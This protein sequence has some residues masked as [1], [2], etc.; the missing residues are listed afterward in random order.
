LPATAGR[1]AEPQR[2]ATA[3]GESRY[4]ARSAAGPAGRE[5]ERNRV[6]RLTLTEPETA[7][8]SEQQHEQAVTALAT[9][10]ASWVERRIY[11]HH[12]TPPT[13]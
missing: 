3:G 11:R 2:A 12:D 6:L 5:P 1:R 8:M 4:P 10:I 7:P 13:S 9:M